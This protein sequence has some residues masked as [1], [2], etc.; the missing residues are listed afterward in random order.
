MRTPA[1]MALVGSVVVCVVFMVL[2]VV[3]PTPVANT[4]D[5]T[6]I[7]MEPPSYPVNPAEVASAAAGLTDPF[8]PRFFE[9]AKFKGMMRNAA[10]GFS[11]IFLD[12]ANQ[13][14]QLVPGQT[15]EGITIVEVDSGKCR[16]LIGSLSRELTVQGNAPYTPALQNDAPPWR[17]NGK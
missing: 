3:E 9:T 15:L 7:M 5:W 16:I 10:G 12:N 2:Y 14:V 1:Y 17:K 11:A 13:M 8:R 6:P 4:T